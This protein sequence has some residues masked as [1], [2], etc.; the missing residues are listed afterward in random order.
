MPRILLPRAPRLGLAVATMLLLG[1][2]AAPVGPAMAETAPA[3][4]GPIPTISGTTSVGSV[5]TVAAGTWTPAPVSLAYRWYVDGSAV[6]GE[7]GQ[8]VTFSI[9]AAEKGKKVQVR[10]TGSR[11]GSVSVTRKSVETRKILASVPAAPPVS[12]PVV[13]SPPPVI[14][15][16]TPVIS[17]AATV[18]STLTADPGAWGPDGVSVSF[19][20][21]VDGIAVT[22]SAGDTAVFIVRSGDVGDRVTV[23]VT[24]SRTGMTPV[25]KKSAE[26]LK[27]TAPPKAAITGPAPLITGSAIVGSTLTADPGAWAP[28]GVTLAYRWHVDG[29][30]VSGAAGEGA[31]FVTRSG[32]AG[33]TITIKVTGSRAGST[34]V[35]KTS[36]A[37]AKVAGAVITGTPPAISGTP[38]VGSTL[39]AD[40]GA[41]GPSPVALAYR[42]YVDGTSVSGTAGG[43]ATF[44]VR[45]G[46]VGD[47]I[48][49]R[50]TA[51]GPGRSR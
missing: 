17:G 39:T 32:D 31:A 38:S 45:S 24:G 28:D 30:A 9:G 35:T 47:A 23:R 25:T 34:S 21:Y 33:K 36:S 44:V 51:H 12:S 4:V 46:D 16:S 27:V 8:S 14:S 41:W 29:K 13:S 2:L 42:W 48:T 37:T 15:G 6:P 40:A 1:G 26:T 19:R 50:V 5:L 3:L 49:V 20:W 10:V 18:G 43:A 7:A 11:P 22:G